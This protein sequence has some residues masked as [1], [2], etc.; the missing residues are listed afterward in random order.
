MW[1]P[2]YYSSLLWHLHEKYLF[3]QNNILLED[4]EELCVVLYEMCQDF[5]MHSDK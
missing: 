1:H 5:K 3:K 4:F 2:G